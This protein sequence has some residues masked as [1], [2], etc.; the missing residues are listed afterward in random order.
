MN[1][2]RKDLEELTYEELKSLH[3]II[4]S[5][6]NERREEKRWNLKKTLRVGMA[7]RIN[8]PKACGLQVI[9][10]KVNQVKAKVHDPLTGSR[11][12]V[13]ITLLEPINK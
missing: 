7:C 13:S 2:T 9:V 12:D 11:Y 4:A 10:D 5:E 8:H 6:L 1:I 3:L